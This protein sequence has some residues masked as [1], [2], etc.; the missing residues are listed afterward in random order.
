MWRRVWAG[1][2]SWRPRTPEVHAQPA[3]V[4]LIG[5]VAAVAVVCIIGAVLSAARQADQLALDQ[6]QRLFANAIADRKARTMVGG[7]STE[8]YLDRNVLETI[9]A[10]LELT[11]LRRV[12]LEPAHEGESVF[13]LVDGDG[14]LPDYFAWTPKRPGAGIVKNITPFLGIAFGCFALL[15][16]FAVRYTRNTAATLSAGDKRLRHLAMHDP[17]SGLPNRTW[18]AERLADL[19]ENVRRTDGRAAVMSIGLDRFNGVN[20]AL[21]H[22]V[23]DGLIHAVAQRLVG[24]VRNDDLVAQLGGDELAVIMPGMS[25]LDALQAMAERIIDAVRAPYLIMGHTIVIGAGIGIARIDRR[26]GEAADIMRRSD[27]ALYRAK[28]DGRNRART[29]DAAMDSDL[30]E[31]LQL[32]HDLGEAIRDGGLNLAY[33]PIVDPSGEVMLGVEALCRWRHPS[34]GNIE[35]ADFI[36][37]AEQ[38]ELIVPLGEWVLRQACREA[39]AW[40]GMVLAVNVSPLQFRRPDF[41]GMVRRVLRDTGFEPARLELE[42]TESTLV[43]DV[44]DALAAMCRLKGLGVRLALDDFGTCYSSLRY[45]RTFPFDR[46]KIDRSFVCDIEI[47][48]DGAAIVHAIVSLGRALGMKVTAEGVESAEQHLFLRVAGVHSM[49][50]FRFG[51]PLGAE[52]LTVRLA[53]QS[54][55]RPAAPRPT[56]AVAG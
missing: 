1:L 35:P 56:A 9:G 48:A 15:A 45:L 2:D 52:A 21:G 28:I 6:E 34:R 55:A 24:V 41:V 53:A 5:L 12:G 30:R 22:R 51:G 33:Q 36:P 38:S 3:A 11:K 14:R 29:Y 47:A 32:E 40:P 19:I 37:I 44:E 31:R 4:A 18:F 17:L 23:G 10:K 25:D 27:V 8:S 46:L 16:T 39:T 26:S 43:G 20:D 54:D 49:Q 50:G 7:E 13:T 42:L